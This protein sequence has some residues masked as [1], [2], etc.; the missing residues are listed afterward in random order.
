MDLPVTAT[1]SFLVILVRS[2]DDVNNDAVINTIDLQLAINDALG[3]GTGYNCHANGDGS[4]NA[5]DIQLDYQRCA[6]HRHLLFII[7]P[8][9]I[10]QHGS[11]H[12]QPRVR[13]SALVCN[14]QP[15]NRMCDGVT[16][17]SRP[18]MLVHRWLCIICAEDGC[19]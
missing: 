6:G 16:L 19:L 18:N 8:L 11:A 5:V 4:V 7:E 10:G 14:T 17:S 2:T 9:R 3:I 1:G 12:S 13:R 15:S